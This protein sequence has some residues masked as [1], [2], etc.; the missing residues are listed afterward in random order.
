[1]GKGGWGGERE[2]GG[3]RGG[4]RIKERVI[5]VKEEEGGHFLFHVQ[6]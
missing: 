4:G 6:E 3:G 1:M 5:K 2:R